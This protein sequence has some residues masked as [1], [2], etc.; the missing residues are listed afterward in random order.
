MVQTVVEVRLSGL[1]TQ[2]T[3]RPVVPTK[4]TATFNKTSGGTTFGALYKAYR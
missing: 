4:Y 1:Y 3:D 2:L